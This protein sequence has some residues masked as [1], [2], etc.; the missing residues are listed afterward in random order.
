M[1]GTGRTYG[2]GRNQFYPM[3]CVYRPDDRIQRAHVTVLRQPSYYFVRLHV[4]T[5]KNT[6]ETLETRSISGKAFSSIFMHYYVGAPGAGVLLKIKSLW[7]QGKVADFV[8]DLF[9]YAKNNTM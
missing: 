1:F 3:Q 7:M 4:K 6:N 2:G 5:T 9:E 8:A